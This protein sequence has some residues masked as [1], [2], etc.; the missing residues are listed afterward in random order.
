LPRPVGRRAVENLRRFAWSN[1]RAD[2]F[3]DDDLSKGS[4]VFKG[5]ARAWNIGSN[6]RYCLHSIVLRMRDC[7]FQW[8]PM[9]SLV[10]CLSTPRRSWSIPHSRH[11]RICSPCPFPN[12]SLRDLAVYLPSTW[13][14]GP[15]RVEAFL[16][17]TFDLAV[18]TV[19]VGAH[20]ASFGGNWPC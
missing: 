20:L 2:W 10:N 9:D 6:S 1:Y 4:Q 14:S 5:V 3:L 16:E 11:S 13:D 8:A 12:A 7:S 18:G 15:K 17:A 19:G